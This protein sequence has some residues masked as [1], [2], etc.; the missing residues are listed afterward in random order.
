[1]NHTHEQLWAEIQQEAALT[2]RYTG[3]GRFSDETMRAIAAVPRAEFVPEGHVSLA[4]EN[5]PLPIGYGQTI[6]QPFVVALMTEL[7]ALSQ[8]S[9]VLEIGTGSGYQA[10]ILAQLA[11]AVFTVERVAEL[12]DLA[13]QR[14]EQFGLDNVHVRQADGYEGWAEQGPFDAII[15][16]AA[17]RQI[18]QALLGQLKPGGRMVIPVGLPHAAQELLRVT[19]DEQEQIHTEPVLTV[20]FVPMV[21]GKSSDGSG[22]VEHSP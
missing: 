6:S 3:I 12:A 10:A 8:E 20:A 21:E 7:L 4:L 9:V 15:V 5:R 17:A 2:E 14:F 11:K 16:T 13:R 22:G 19:K 18:P 1:L